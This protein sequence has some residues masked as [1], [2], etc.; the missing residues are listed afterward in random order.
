MRNYKAKPTNE[1]Y[2]FVLTFIQAN[3]KNVIK[4]V[5]LK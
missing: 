1:I 3:Q 4:A 2:I 5:D